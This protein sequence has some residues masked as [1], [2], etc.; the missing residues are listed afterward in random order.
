MVS[1][2]FIWGKN[3]QQPVEGKDAAASKK[4]KAGLDP[5]PTGEGESSRLRRKKTSQAPRQ[6][7]QAPES[8][9]YHPDHVPNW[10]VKESDL[11]R[12]TQVA[13]QMIHHFATPADRQVLAEHSSETVEAALCKHLAQVVTFVSDFSERFA[14]AS[15]KTLELDTQLHERDELVDSQRKDLGELTSKRQSLGPRIQ[16]LEEELSRVNSL[17]RRYE[18]EYVEPTK[19]PEVEVFI[20][21]NLQ[22]AWRK[23][24]QTHATE[25]LRAHPDLDL[26]NVRSIKEI[27]AELE[28]DSEVADD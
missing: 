24:F 11:S 7:P 19:L 18:R 16:E 1:T 13:R 6:L 15:K 14:Q 17:N 20:Q 25:V 5:S 26:S 21:Q 10:G 28:E 8:P 2:T 4:G 9:P 22:E 23:G 12:N 3:K 27:V